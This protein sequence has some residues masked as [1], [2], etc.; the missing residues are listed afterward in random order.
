MRKL[1]A[2]SL[3]TAFVVG[4]AGCSKGIS[5][6]NKTVAYDP[7]KDEPV[8]MGGPKKG[9]TKSDFTAPTEPAGGNKQ[10]PGTNK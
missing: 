9:R 7:S 6:P 5:E 2:L 1:L 10:P 3:V 8:I 4:A